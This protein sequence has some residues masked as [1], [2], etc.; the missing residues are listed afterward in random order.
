MQSVEPNFGFYDYYLKGEF[1]LSSST[2]LTLKHFGSRDNFSYTYNKLYLRKGSD[3]M[4]IPTQEDYNEQSRWQNESSGIKISQ[5]WDSKLKSE[6][7]I[8]YA[9]FDLSED[10]N[11]GLSNPMRPVQGLKIAIGNN[12]DNYI[13][14]FQI[15]WNNELKVNR[16]LLKFGYQ[17]EQAES[18]IDLNIDEENIFNLDHQT[19]QHI[20]FLGLENSSNSSTNWSISSRFNMDKLSN[21]F[22]LAPRISLKHFI[23]P[24]TLVK[25]ATSYNQQTLRESY[26]EDR[27]GRGRSFWVLSNDDRLPILSSWNTMF[28]WAHSLKNFSIDMEAY[29]NRIQGVTQYA[30]VFPKIP[31]GQSNNGPKIPPQLE[32]FSGSGTNYGIDWTFTFKYKKFET[33]LAYSLSKSTQLIKELNRGNAYPSQDDRRHQLK[34]LS[35]LNLGKWNFYINSYFSNG[36]PY[37][38]LTTGE[39]LN[40]NRRNIPFDQYVKNLD[41]YKRIDVGLDYS[42][43]IGNK[44]RLNLGASV[45]NVTNIQNEAYRQNVYALDQTNS[46]AIYGN[47]V[48]LL[49]A[50]PTIYIKASF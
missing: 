14:L 16:F 15:Q 37:L 49:N 26:Y 40:T 46:S 20:G 27:F 38:D 47:S 45:F 3:N 35:N 44:I 34:W 50:T 21:K 22:L 41:P 43:N 2:K 48:Q 11:I 12:F 32:L 24:Q 42:L 23:T 18:K 9:T 36:K 30:L 7:N 29:Y 10:I 17:F 19:N 28:G 4:M 33:Q 1:N 5:I 39:F 13:D 6:F 31:S 25:L 8:N